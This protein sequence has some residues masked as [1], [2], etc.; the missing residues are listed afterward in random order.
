MQPLSARREG[1]AAVTIGSML[2]VWA[3]KAFRKKARCRRCKQPFMLHT[4]F[5]TGKQIPLELDAKPVRATETQA[6]TG[7]HYDVYAWSDVHRCLTKPAR[8]RASKP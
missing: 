6:D 2:Y 4:R 3:G 8:M 7:K 5:D 1:G